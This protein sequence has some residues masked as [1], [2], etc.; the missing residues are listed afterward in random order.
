MAPRPKHS[1]SYYRT[2]FERLSRKQKWPGHPGWCDFKQ[3][4]NSIRMRQ[5]LAAEDNARWYEDRDRRRQKG[6]SSAGGPAIVVADM[7]KVNMN[8]TTNTSWADIE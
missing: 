7:K 6:I 5:A 4:V 3:G 1:S 2:K 8:P